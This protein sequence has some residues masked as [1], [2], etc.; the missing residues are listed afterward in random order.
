MATI[1]KLPSGNYQARV[2]HPGLRKQV[3]VG[4]PHPLKRVAQ[5]AGEDAEQKIR[6][7]EWIDREL[8]E[9]TLDEWW[10]KWSA[11]RTVERSTAD[12][13]LGRYRTHIQPAFGSWT[14]NALAQA[15]EDVATWVAELG[16][17]GV[18]AETMAG[19]LRLLGQVLG[20]ATGAVKYRRID[21]NPCEGIKA[22]TPPK[23]EDRFLTVLESKILRLQFHGEARLLIETA[24][25]TG[26]RWAELAGLRVYR[27]DTRAQKLT[28][29]QVLRR[30]GEVKDTPKSAA[31]ARQ[32][33]LTPG[34]TRKLAGHMK[35][36]QPGDL[37][38]TAPQGG[39]LLYA[40][41][42]TRV[43]TPARKRAGLADPQPTF[44]D[45]RHTYGSWLAERGVPLTD[46]KDLMGHAKLQSCERY[47]HASPSRLA[48]ARAVLDT[49]HVVGTTPLV[50]LRGGRDR[51]APGHKKTRP[52]L[53]R[54][55]SG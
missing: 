35:G 26:L 21:V 25:G 22:P 37:V 6:R 2:W 15:S 34:L 7:G 5:R 32:V 23:H 48:R 20:S 4:K 12:K 40:T 1:R 45:L 54:R 11:M 27:I 55:Q 49:R 10:A 19:S 13:D 42:R 33:P 3:P 47:L 31:G 44:H 52:D 18:G 29:A 38:F 53:H 14:L 8:G 46:I 16:K 50:P 24:L 51:A 39:P 9:I 43:W 17:R 41:W 36:K 30:N 28:V